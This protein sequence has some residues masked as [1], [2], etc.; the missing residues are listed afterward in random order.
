M[1]RIG[2]IG[3]NGQV[4][5][6]VCLLLRMMDEFE[7]VPIC[8]T[9][10]AGAFL[11]RCGFNP[12]LGRVDNPDHAPTL[13]GN[14]DVIADFSLPSGASSGVR[15]AMRSVIPNIARHAPAGIPM[16]YLSSITAFGIPDFHSPLRE[17]L[18]SRNNYGACKRYAEGLVR[19]HGAE[20]RRDI[21]ILRVGVV[22]GELQAVTRKCL[23][24]V[25]LAGS[26]PTYIP[27]CE[28]FTVFAFS[29]AE[30]IAGIARGREEPGSYTML[31]NPGWSWQDVHKWYCSR[32][33]VDGNV[34]LLGP[35]ADAPPSLSSAAGTALGPAKRAG[36]VVKD[37]VA[38]YL[39]AA[40]PS[41]ESKLRG[42]YHRNGAAAE[43]GA[44]R[45]TSQYRPYGNNHSVF[46]GRRPVSISDSRVTMAP[47]AAD[48]RRFLS[49]VV[50]PGGSFPTP[51][52][53][54]E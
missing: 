28:S 37:I 31:S 10:I 29:I 1:K 50:R 16:V 42:V 17:Y 49:E 43:I 41:V 3:A 40:L 15:A 7:P 44:G 54:A 20:T 18:F 11:R 23:R 36:R 26:T 35:D 48:L 21:Y 14:L 2:I 22:H 27:D 19:K 8:R 32:A 25:R 9:E 38:G 34:V 45:R 6:E 47:Y 13:L 46:P 30:A 53:V 12:R 52:A 5:T 24:D 33:G 51:T 4:G 39:G